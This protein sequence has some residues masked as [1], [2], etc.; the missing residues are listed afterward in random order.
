MVC[1]TLFVHIEK[2][3]HWNLGNLFQIANQ[4]KIS[5]N[6]Y[7]ADEGYGSSVR[8]GVGTGLALPFP[9]MFAHWKLPTGAQPNSSAP[10]KQKT[11]IRTHTNLVLNIDG[12]FPLG[13]IQQAM[14]LE[15]KIN[16]SLMILMVT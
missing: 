1:G 7:S 13:E 15:S 10:M 8:W 2:A 11:E 6:Q 14:E 9:V 3:H 16:T 12:Q 4:T 5:G